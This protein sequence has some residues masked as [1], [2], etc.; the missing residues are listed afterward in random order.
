M[1]LNLG[2][3]ANAAGVYRITCLVNGWVYIGQTTC[4]VRRAREHD[5][6][7]TNGRL[8]DAVREHGSD[9]FM[10]EVVAVISDPGERT[11]EEL[12]LIRQAYGPGCYNAT[13]RRTPNNTGRKLPPRSQDTREKLRQAHLGKKQSPETIAKKRA[14]MTTP[15]AIERIRQVHLGRRQ[16]PEA[17]EKRRQSN[18]GFRHSPETVEKMR[19][20][21]M[22]A[23]NREKLRAANLGKKKSPEMIAKMRGRSPSAETREKIRRS[24]LGKSLS[25]EHVESVRRSKAGTRPSPE[26]LEASRRASLGRKAS[27]ETIEKLRLS[28]LGKKQS[29]ETIAKRAATRAATMARRAASAQMSLGGLT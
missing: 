13:D 15:E 29:E 19:N 27:P 2:E 17:V 3:H 4:F 20:R 5:S 10:M 7:R 22:S 21:K 11:R 28:H 8:A 23:E 14:A 26:C 16:S 12:R 1:R 6:G 25:P 24:L 9:A 18:K